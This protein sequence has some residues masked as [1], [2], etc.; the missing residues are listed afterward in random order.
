[1][2]RSTSKIGKEVIPND[3]NILVVRFRIGYPFQYAGKGVGEKKG[4]NKLHYITRT[5]GQYIMARRSGWCYLMKEL[6]LIWGCSR[7]S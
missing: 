5:R 4:E 1:M 2:D 6:T 7:R 3:E